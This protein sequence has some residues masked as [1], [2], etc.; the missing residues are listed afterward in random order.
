MGAIELWGASMG[1]KRVVF[2]GSLL[3]FLLK[4]G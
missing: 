3:S 4:G 1:G 2:G